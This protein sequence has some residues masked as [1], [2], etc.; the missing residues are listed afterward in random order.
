MLFLLAV[1][2]TFM[3]ELFTSAWQAVSSILLM[4]SCLGL[5]PPPEAPARV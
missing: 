1:V 4:N 2:P 5:R 3:H